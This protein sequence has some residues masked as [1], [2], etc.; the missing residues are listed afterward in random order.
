MPTGPAA[1]TVALCALLD[2][3]LR[4]LADVP[5][6]EYTRPGNERGTGS[7]GGHVR[8]V[9]DHVRALLRARAEGD[10]IDYDARERGTRVEHE[11]AVARSE[12]EQLIADVRKADLDRRLADAIQVR[13][14]VQP[15]A[16]PLCSTSTIGRELA[17]V[18]SHTI[19]HQAMIADLLKRHGGRVPDDF[20]YAPATV[21]HFQR[22]PCARSAS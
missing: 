10:E 4:L 14:L 15:D 12:T 21:Q 2:Q 5:V 7:I 11:P 9:L 3:T 8:H 18:V 19:H 13:T 17:F 16:D 22:T 1:P 6:A 20:G